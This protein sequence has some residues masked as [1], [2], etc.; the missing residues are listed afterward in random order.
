M[1]RLH[2][3]IVAIAGISALALVTACSSDDSS[4]SEATTDESSEETSADDGGADN[5]DLTIGFVPGIA[6]DPFF[7][8]MQQGAEEHADDLGI[9]LIWQGAP[10]EYSPQSQIPFVETMITQ[11]VDGLIVVPTDPDALQDSVDTAIGQGIPTATVDT[12][13]TDQSQ[14]VSHI[15]GDN[16]DGGRLA[17]ETLAELIGGE[18]EVFIMSGSPTATTNTLRE[19][20]F[21]EA[22]AEYPDI[23]IV[24][25]EYA[26][27]QPAAATTAVST[28]L[29]Q[30]PEL[31]GIFAIDGT[32][33]TGTVAALRNAGVDGEVELIGYDAYENQ[34][35]DLQDGVFSA[36][37]AQKPGDMARLAIDYI[38][39]AI[40]GD[41]SEIEPSVVMENVVITMDNFDETGQYAYPS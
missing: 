13:V 37:I 14:L 30:Y 33:G 23:E 5:S 35:A 15:T 28:I 9:E 32:S 24:G 20:G 18:G 25:L 40:N 16:V 11:E 22:M 31:D 4:T 29:L 10:D 36:L 34:I 12:T 38:I 8:A 27:S 17:G 3:S 7:L 41:V 19:E 39:D 21:R 2:R 1:A 26:N 6:S